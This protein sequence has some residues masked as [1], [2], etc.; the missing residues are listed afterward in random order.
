MDRVLVIKR[1]VL[2]ELEFLRRIAAVLLGGIVLPLANR[3][4]QGNLLYWSLLLVAS[5]FTLL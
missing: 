1:T 5:H 2:R 3:A 4:L